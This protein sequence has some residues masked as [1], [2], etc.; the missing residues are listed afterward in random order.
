VGGIDEAEVRRSAR[1]WCAFVALCGVFGLG[2]FVFFLS[3]YGD[4]LGRPPAGRVD[5]DYTWQPDGRVQAEV[6]SSA[7]ALQDQALLADALVGS[8]FPPGTALEVSYPKDARITTYSVR[9]TT[10]DPI[11]DPAAPWAMDLDRLVAA[12]PRAGV[13]KADVWVRTPRVAHRL[14]T[15]TPPTG[16][17]S[18][19]FGWEDVGEGKVPSWSVVLEASPAA[20]AGWAAASTVVALVLVALTAVVTHRAA[21]CRMPEGRARVWLGVVA[22][23]GFFGA[24]VAAGAT[25]GDDLAVGFGWSGPGLWVA[26]WT[27]SLLCLLAVGWALLGLIASVIRESKRRSSTAGRAPVVA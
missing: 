1:R 6:K 14:T 16:N 2:F 11:A 12:L 9:A 25:T 15:S 27:A 24:V 4:P 19:S 5:V 20:T 13:T 18:A 26:T 8:L 22:F 10:M 7:W 21:W 3:I 23:C 17:Y